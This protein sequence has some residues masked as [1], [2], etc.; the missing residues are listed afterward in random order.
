MVF[1]V[2]VKQ[3]YQSYSIGQST[4]SKVIT[5]TASLLNCPN[6][7]MKCP[8]LWYRGRSMPTLIPHS[9]NT[10]SAS[11]WWQIVKYLQRVAETKVPSSRSRYYYIHLRGDCGVVV[12]QME[13]KQILLPLLSSICATFVFVQSV[14]SSILKCKSKKKLWFIPYIRKEKQNKTCF[15]LPLL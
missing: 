2:L 5:N 6:S 4:P 15:L 10:S 11:H 7:I 8:T 13:L 14:S 12:L 3:L 1:H 9:F